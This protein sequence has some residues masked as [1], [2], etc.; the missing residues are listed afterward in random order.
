LVNHAHDAANELHERRQVAEDAE[1]GGDR[2]LWMIEPFAE[3][4]DLD[5]DVKLLESKS[6][7]LRLGDAP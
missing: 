5:D 6:T 2:K 4:S 7:A 3:L 1:D